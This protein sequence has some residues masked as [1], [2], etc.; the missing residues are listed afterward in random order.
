MDGVYI[1]NPGNP[2]ESKKQDFHGKMPLHLS[3]FLFLF[4]IQL[5]LVH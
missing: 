1:P 2:D 5:S 3:V 4:L